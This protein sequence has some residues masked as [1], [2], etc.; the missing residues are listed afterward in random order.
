[1]KNTYKD[2]EQN[3]TQVPVYYNAFNGLRGHRKDSMSLTILIQSAL[4]L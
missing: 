3:I 1:M 2:D 4:T